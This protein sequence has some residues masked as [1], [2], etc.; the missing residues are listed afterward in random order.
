[1]T[2]GEKVKRVCINT[3]KVMSVFVLLYFFICSL[4]F[5]SS[6][7]RLIAGP[8]TGEYTKLARALPP[9]PDA[10]CRLAVTPIQ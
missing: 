6:A 1:M 10:K 7:F 3:C 4:D 5:L 8:T 9:R 2:T